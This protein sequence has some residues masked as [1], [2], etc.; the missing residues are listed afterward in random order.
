MG[1][2]IYLWPVVKN[3]HLKTSLTLRQSMCF[4]SSA[5]PKVISF[6]KK[7]L[8]IHVDPYQENGCVTVTSTRSDEL[9]RPFMMCA[10][11]SLLSQTCEC[12]SCDVKNKWCEILLHWAWN[13]ES[14]NVSMNLCQEKNKMD[15]NK[16][17]VLRCTLDFNI[18]ISSS[19]H[20]SSVSAKL[21]ITDNLWKNSWQRCAY[22]TLKCCYRTK[23]F[24]FNENTEKLGMT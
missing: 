19:R 24:S 23:P 7:K 13:E 18:K 22:K 4:K 12:I 9:Q 15:G 20:Q 14:H 8:F 5:Y 3:A 6:W 1:K 10:W 2:N 16:P 11:L 21:W 17:E